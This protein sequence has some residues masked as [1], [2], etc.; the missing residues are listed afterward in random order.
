MRYVNGNACST[1]SPGLHPPP[2]PPLQG[3]EFGRSALCLAGLAGVLFGW[4]PAEFWSATPAELMAL[5][6]VLTGETVA[7]PDAATLAQLREAFPDG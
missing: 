3:G 4:R 2:T 1:G 7:P 6:R 5:V